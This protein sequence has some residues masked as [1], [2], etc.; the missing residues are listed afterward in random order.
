MYYSDSIIIKL[1]ITGKCRVTQFPPQVFIADVN[2]FIQE[3]QYPG[4]TV[5][6]RWVGLEDEPQ[7]HNG[8]SSEPQ[9]MQQQQH[10]PGSQLIICIRTRLT[11]TRFSRHLSQS[12]KWLPAVQQCSSFS[13][14]KQLPTLFVFAVCDLA[15]TGL[16]ARCL[17]ASS[18]KQREEVQVVPS[19]LGAP[20]HSRGVE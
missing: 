18:C 8:G 19:V 20:Q 2:R 11:Q 12:S 17:R 15:A 13:W 3:H 6:L 16:F 4:W 9:E 14:E 1:Y 10:G 7:C 5:R